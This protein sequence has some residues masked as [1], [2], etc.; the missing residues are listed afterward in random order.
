VLDAAQVL[1]DVVGAGDA[2]EHRPFARRADLQADLAEV[3]AV[4]ELAGHVLD[5]EVVGDDRV[6]G[7]GVALVTG[8][9]V[10]VGVRSA[11]GP[12]G[13]RADGE[14]DGG[15]QAGEAPD[16]DRGYADAALR[17]GWDGGF[18]KHGG[19]RAPGGLSFVVS[20]A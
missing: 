19:I 2:D 6:A 14:Q 18:G 8:R 4:G 7:G 11:V 20:Q 16:D 3:V 9:V 12:E 10:A 15:E 13:E 1:V 5:V 17:R